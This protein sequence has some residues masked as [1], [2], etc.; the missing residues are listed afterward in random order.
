MMMDHGRPICW[1]PA[2]KSMVFPEPFGPSCVREL[3]DQR[4]IDTMKPIVANV[5]KLTGFHGMCGID[6]IRRPDGSFAVLEFNPRPTS[7]IHLS[8][9]LGADCAI[10][11]RAMFAGQVAPQIP[12]ECRRSQ[13]RVYMFPQFWRRTT[14]LRRWKDLWVYIPFVANHDI[15]W[16]EP[17]FVVSHLWGLMKL[18]S[19]YLGGLTTGL[20]SRRRPGRQAVRVPTRVRDDRA[21]EVAV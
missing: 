15:P 18:T 4:G 8:Q 21:E 3:L 1:V 20:W 14:R 13:R 6:W 10:A 7:T 9:R 12:V 11:L 5:G 16:E 19:S 2:Y 17:G